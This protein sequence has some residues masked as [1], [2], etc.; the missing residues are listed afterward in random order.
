MPDI[1]TAFS[2][3]AALLLLV[4]T[5]CTHLWTVVLSAFVTCA[6]VSGR[7]PLGVKGKPSVPCDSSVWHMKSNHMIR[8][9]LMVSESSFCPDTA[10]VCV[11]VCVRAGRCGWGVG[12]C[13]QLTHAAL[14][15]LD[16]GRKTELG[17]VKVQHT[18]GEF[19]GIKILPVSSLELSGETRGTTAFGLWSITICGNQ[20][21]ALK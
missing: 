11:C 10:W 5:F 3:H 16:R 17:R 14:S 15:P 21:T 19:S 9:M 4:F 7:L 6:L 2:C 18:S 8:Q 1:S 20:P 13:L 12:T